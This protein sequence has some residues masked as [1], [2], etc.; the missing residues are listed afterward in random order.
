MLVNQRVKALVLA[1]GVRV[2]EA[3]VS[4]VK[5]LHTSLLGSSKAILILTDT[6][7]I[8][9]HISLLFRVET[10]SNKLNNAH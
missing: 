1:V 3:T 4:S 5:T 2:G 10:S 7:T 6:G 9:L 8:Q